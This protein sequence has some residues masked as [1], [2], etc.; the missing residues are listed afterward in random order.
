MTPLQMRT[1]RRAAPIEDGHSVSSNG[2][3]NVTAGTVLEGKYRLEREV[4]AG[5]M[6]Q[7]FLAEHETIE[8]TVAIKVLH[9]ELASD[10]SV[11]RRFETEAK[12][13][14]R[15][16]HPNC[17]M[18]YEFGY[19]DEIEALFAVFEYV[20]GTSLEHHIGK[21]LPVADVLEVGK[22]VADGIDHAHDQ[23][24]IHRDLK[25]ENI[26][27]VSSKGEPVLKVLDFGIARIAEDDE[28]STRLTKMGQMFG[29]PPYMSPEQVRAKLNIT[30]ATDIYAIGVILY[31]LLEGELP[32]IGDTPIATVMMHLNDEVPPIE[33]DDVPDE[34]VAI[35]MRCLEKEA[36][37]RFSSCAALQQALHEVEWSRRQPSMLV[38]D[39]QFEAE[40]SPS[41]SDDALKATLGT[42]EEGIEKSERDES[43]ESGGEVDGQTPDDIA[44]APT[45]MADDVGEE[46]SSRRVGGD[47][48]REP[49]AGAAGAEATTT[50][51]FDD[52]DEDLAG[53]GE[54]RTRLVIAAV[55]VMALIV[56]GGAVAMVV[57][58]S[59]FSDAGD[60][61]DEQTASADPESGQ[62]EGEGAEDSQ[63]QIA[64]EPSSS[65][66]SDGDDGLDEVDDGDY[67]DDDDTAETDGTAEA[68]DTDGDDGD[69]Q[70]AAD[71]G[72]ETGGTGGDDE[73]GDEPEVAGEPEAQEASS[74][75][76]SPQPQPEESP[77]EESPPEEESDDDDGQQPDSI[78]WRRRD[79]DDDNGDSDEEDDVE[80]PEG[81]GLPPRD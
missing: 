36:G 80:Q 24:V 29:T 79:G 51:D 47:D 67:G 20:E 39:D 8:R 50:D 76:P 5:G 81:I 22:Q 38:D 46:G 18:L 30:F 23:N 69:D 12:A 52:F 2:E 37:H 60:A 31:E 11:R 58:P 17:V 77:P 43:A 15:L 16:K 40:Q 44:S 62:E 75:E 14:A 13:I 19:S 74:P 42:P 34:L 28:K 55:A 71:D 3:H 53:W 59:D 10:E 4:G 61:P 32:F 66:E 6:G 64:I 65:D 68:G 41:A 35:I 21:Q 54:R 48:A 7:V 73:A 45:M 49:A 9:Q 78:E 27:A 70:W 26:M 33:R 25:P 72:D 56:L 1:P 57:L 63:E